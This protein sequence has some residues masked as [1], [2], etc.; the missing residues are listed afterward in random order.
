MG[1]D[2]RWG[3][4]G[5]EENEERCEGVVFVGKGLGDEEF[6]GLARGG[7]RVLVT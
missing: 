2:F 5:R 4:L 1:V 3:R 7:G 6:W